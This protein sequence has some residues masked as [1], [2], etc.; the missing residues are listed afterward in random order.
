M[1]FGQ[2]LPHS[3]NRIMGLGQKLLHSEICVLEG[4]IADRIMGLEKKC[5]TL[6]S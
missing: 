5:R 2:K 4:H 3:E 6:K 1:G